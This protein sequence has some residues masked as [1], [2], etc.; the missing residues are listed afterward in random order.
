MVAPDLVAE[1]VLY[2]DDCSVPNVFLKMRECFE[3]RIFIRNVRPLG[4]E[5]PRTDSRNFRGVCL[6]RRDC[7]R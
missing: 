5:K 3:G 4:F 7:G 1:S 2:I 6:R